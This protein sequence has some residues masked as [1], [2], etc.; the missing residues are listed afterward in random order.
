MAW[1][2]RKAR[3]SGPQ[4]RPEGRPQ[5]VPAGVLPALGRGEQVLATARED[6]GGAWVVLTTF[7]LLERTEEGETLLERPWHEVDT[8]SWDPE[9]WTLSVVFVDGRQGRQWALRRRTGPG[10]VPEVFRDRTTATV[11]LTQ[12]IDLG[13]RRTARVSVRT[14]LETRELVEQV[15]LGRGARAED[16]ELAARV[17]QT[18]RDL[19]EQSGMEPPP[20]S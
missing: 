12:A 2:S 10:R 8:G 9:R 7:R 15:L 4:E 14:V 1:W 13:P 5:D 6:A 3:R 19:R 17:E 11:V 18:R 20:V 16:R